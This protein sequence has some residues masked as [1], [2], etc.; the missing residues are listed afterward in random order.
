MSLSILSISYRYCIDSINSFGLSW[1]NMDVC[2]LS[3]SICF[4]CQLPG[5]GVLITP[6]YVFASSYVGYAR[7]RFSGFSL[8]E[9]R[10]ECP[11]CEQVGIARTFPLTWR[12]KS[13]LI[14]QKLLPGILLMTNCVFFG[15]WL[16]VFLAVEQT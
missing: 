4:N 15:F 12:A 3:L 9:F 11:D 2:S 5:T 16:L 14:P 8:G 6:V 7:A 13:H 10:T 1:G